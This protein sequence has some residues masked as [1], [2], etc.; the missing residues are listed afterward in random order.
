MLSPELPLPAKLRFIRQGFRKRL[1]PSGSYKLGFKGGEIVLSYANNETD[2]NV[3]WDVFINR[4]YKT[5]F[6]MS[7]VVDIGAHKGYFGAYALMHGAERV[8]SY[9]PEREN[10]RLLTET[11]RSFRGQESEW[12]TH[13][14]AVASSPGEVELRVDPE[15]WA[16]SLSSLNPSA[17]TPETDVQIVACAA[18]TDVLQSA[19]RSSAG[20]RLIVK[21]DAE[22]AECEIV[23][24]TPV[25]SWQSVSEV[26]VEVHDF[27]ACSATQLAD[28]LR[29]AGLDLVSE[30]F[31]V[32]HM[33]RSP[34]P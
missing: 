33:V 13:R 6:R 3:V 18:M 17:V 9:E 4:C 15:S 23:L 14:S 12:E 21:I 25:E 34:C 5:D 16:H 8:L 19:I 31:G 29:Q 20:R 24:K 10:F 7:A 27:A 11:S 22:G 2:R 30:R 32:L 28:H 26:F 1:P